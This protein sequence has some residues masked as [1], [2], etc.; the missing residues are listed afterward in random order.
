MVW[1]C[2]TPY[3]LP[4][5]RSRFYRRGSAQKTS[6]SFCGGQ[7]GKHALHHFFMSSRDLICHGCALRV[8]LSSLVFVDMKTMRHPAPNLMENK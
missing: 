3:S 5:G 1:V 7:R 2:T 6:T 4:C 8:S